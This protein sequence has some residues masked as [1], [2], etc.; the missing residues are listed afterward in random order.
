ME[1]GD[2]GG[3][4]PREVSMTWG[5]ACDV[6]VR[7]TVL[8]NLEKFW[9][10]CAGV[11]A[12]TCLRLH[13]RGEELPGQAPRCAE[14]L[15]NGSNLHHDGRGRD[16]SLSCRSVSAFTP[17]RVFTPYPTTND[18]PEPP[19]RVDVPVQGDHDQRGRDNLRDQD[20][21]VRVWHEH[22]GLRRGGAYT[23]RTCSSLLG[24]RGLSFFWFSAG[25]RRHRGF[26]NAKQPW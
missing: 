4:Y 8:P 23:V 21:P 1:A 14:R 9:P 17:P 20:H 25:L 26:S 10:R 15:R 16:K 12:N 11:Q 3:F 18:V 7:A 19:A 5:E 2:E 22:R 24:F 6:E 13:R